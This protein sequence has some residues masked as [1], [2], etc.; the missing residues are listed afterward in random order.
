MASKKKGQ[1][2][3]AKQRAKSRF[4][5][6]LNQHQYQELIEKI[7]AGRVESSKRLSLRVTEHIIEYQGKEMKVLYDKQR[8][9][10]ITFLPVDAP[11]RKY[12]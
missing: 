12:S 11:T 6:D 10:I 7:Q 8:K 2:S 3:H 4:G 5:I 1:R 9:T